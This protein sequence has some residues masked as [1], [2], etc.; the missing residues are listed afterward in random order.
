M[1]SLITPTYMHFS[2]LVAADSKITSF[3]GVQ[4]GDRS[5]LLFTLSVVNVA[6]SVYSS[7]NV[8]FL[9]D[10]TLGGSLESFVW[11]FQQVIPDLKLLRLE[12][13]LSK[14]VINVR[15]GEAEF[16]DVLLSTQSILTGAQLTPKDAIC[17]L[18]SSILLKVIRPILW[19]CPG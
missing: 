13:I 15:C 14:L 5:L 4:Y 16:Q 10:M 8:W 18:G 19:S 11:D 9:D 7:F 12:T 3:S 17:S 6:P 2:S 1:N